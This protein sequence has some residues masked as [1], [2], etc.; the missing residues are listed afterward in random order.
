M[1]VPT[2]KVATAEGELDVGGL[3]EAGAEH[4]GVAETGREVGVVGERAGGGQPR[5]AGSFFAER[6]VV[7]GGY[8]DGHDV[9]PAPSLHLLGVAAAQV[10]DEPLGQRISQVFGAAEGEERV[11]AAL[12]VPEGGVVLAR[13]VEE[14]QAGV[15][16][17]LQASALG[18]EEVLAGRG[19]EADR[20]VEGLDEA[21][22]ELAEVLP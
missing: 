19:A 2:R 11:V 7:E 5:L 14:H 6:W 3:A 18:G 4:G 15:Q 10:A 12:R 9:L 21:V 20:E 22:V 17:G 1:A 8:G 16:H 13:R